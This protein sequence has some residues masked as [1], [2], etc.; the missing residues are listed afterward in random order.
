MQE[1]AMRIFLVVVSGFVLTLTLFAGGVA[2]A[3]YFLSAEPVEEQPVDL[4]VAEVWTNQPVAVDTASQDFDR[5]PAQPPGSSPSSR[6]RHR[7]KRAKPRM[8]ATIAA[9]SLTRP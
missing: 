8:W 6:N 7:R 9:I 1:R 2:T 4:N 3:V 5:L